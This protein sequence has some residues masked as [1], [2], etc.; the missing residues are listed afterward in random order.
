MQ[1]THKL[2]L[3]DMAYYHEK[4]KKFVQSYQGLKGHKG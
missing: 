3:R 1:E 2:L 4:F